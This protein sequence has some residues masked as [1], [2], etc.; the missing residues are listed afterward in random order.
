MTDMCD[1]FIAS[2]DEAL[3]LD[4]RKSPLRDFHSM[5]GLGMSRQHL[6]ELA[7][8]IYEVTHGAQTADVYWQ[9]P[10]H[11]TPVPCILSLPP[12]GRW[13][14]RAH[15]VQVHG[16]A[17]AWWTRT[18]WADEGVPETEAV[19]MLHALA[20]MA[21]SAYASDKLVFLW[22]HEAGADEA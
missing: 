13:L 22:V 19:Q 18:G 17:T 12:I 10:G 8:V 16:W 4:P 7:G 6:R 15:P 9:E 14:G 11:Q 2:V 5:A 1:F 21:A 3:Q 20:V